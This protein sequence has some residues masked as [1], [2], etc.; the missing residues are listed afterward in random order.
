MLAPAQWGA[1][2]AVF[3]ALL[4]EMALKYSDKLPC[5][6]RKPQAPHKRNDGDGGDAPAATGA[7][8]NGTV[9]RRKA[10]NHR[11]ES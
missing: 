2:S 8:A 9:R 1:V 4:G 3:A 5:F 11:N 6:G 7:S 10:G